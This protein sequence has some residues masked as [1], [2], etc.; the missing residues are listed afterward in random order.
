V[1]I[2][3]KCGSKNRTFVVT[4]RHR[5]RARGP[6]GKMGWRADRGRDRKNKSTVYGK[7]LLQ[8]G[9]GYDDCTNALTFA[10]LGWDTRN[11][12]KGV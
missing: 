5:P 2:G 10:R 3:K 4:F 12:A 1:K 8:N 9:F 6:R 7:K 11:T